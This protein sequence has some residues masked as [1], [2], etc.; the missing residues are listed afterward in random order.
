MYSQ[1]ILVENT[2]YSQLII[3]SISL[4][5]FFFLFMMFNYVL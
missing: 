5:L 4:S 2:M 1:L 3:K